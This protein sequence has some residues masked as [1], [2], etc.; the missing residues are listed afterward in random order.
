[1][2]ARLALLDRDEIYQI[3]LATL[4][5]L[6]G[7]GTT[8]NSSK[9]L[10]ILADAGAY[11]DTQTKIVKF[12]SYIVEEALRNAPKRVVLCGRNPKNDIKLE[13]GRVHFGLGSAPSLNS[14]MS[15]FDEDC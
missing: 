7:T 2:K 3:H 14:S 5:I 1:M 8:V 6:E 9:A 10:K 11:V 12:P 13:D 15:A 4:E